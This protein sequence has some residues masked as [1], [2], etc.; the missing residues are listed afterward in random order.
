MQ[1]NAGLPAPKTVAELMEL[2][3]EL[4]SRKSVYQM[5]I[6]HIRICYQKS[7]SGPAE[8][9]ITREDLGIVPELH[10]EKTVVEIEE[11]INFIDAQIEE[12]QGQPVGGGTPPVA[13]AAPATNAPPAEDP[14]PVVSTAPAPE[15]LGS[16]LQIGAGPG[17]PPKTAEKK[18]VPSGKPR[19]PGGRPS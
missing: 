8:M 2:I 17:Q 18:E 5:L 11:R 14:A 19:T 13:E 6:A 9:K 3:S 1:F 16:V 4:R 7:D 10:I 15:A 12:L